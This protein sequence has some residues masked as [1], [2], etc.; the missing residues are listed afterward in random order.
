MKIDLTKNTIIC[1]DN[2]KWLENIPDRSF[3]LCY[4]DPPYFS[5]KNRDIVWKNG[6][7]RHSFGDKFQGDVRYY[8][9]WMRPRIELIHRK[10]K[11]TGSIFL[12]CDW[13]A[14]HRL[15][16]LLDDIFK[17][18]NFRNEIIWQRTPFSGSSKSR[19]QQFPVIHDTIFYYAKSKEHKTFICP[20]LPYSEEYLRRFKHKDAV[21]YYRKTLLKTYSEETLEKLK[22]ENKLILPQKEGAKYSYKQYLDTSRGTIPIGTIWTDINMLN[23]V[24]KERIGYPTQ[25]PEKLIE[26]IIRCASKEGDLILDCFVGGGTTAKVCADLNR[27]FIVGDVS[28]VAV[29]MTAT[30]LQK[31]GVVRIDIKNLAKTRE[32]FLNMNATDFEK[33]V[34]DVR[35]W[36]H[37]GKVNDHN[38]DG[39][40]PSQQ[41][42]QI[43]NHNKP[44]G[45]GEIEKF[46]G[47]LVANHKTKGIFVAWDYTT[48]ARAKAAF[49]KQEQG[50][51]IDLM[52]CKDALE[53]L[54]LDTEHDALY[55]KIFNKLAPEEWR[56]PNINVIRNLEEV[57]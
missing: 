50:I 32:Q 49:Y 13:H 16:G 23:P 11:E 21:G 1:G 37:T 2:V 54:I 35:G 22:Q 7:E 55:D 26:R 43:K 4:I 44:T 42:I 17:S 20:S 41:I 12:Q 52:T 57:S 24:A 27:R 31:V 36:E 34:C 10:L 19:S 25:K 53:S 5:G 29:R 33:F 38:I 40:T 51:E 28:P 3:D 30:R 9:E 48:Q 47:T 39:Y 45:P 6:T 18:Q 8:I 56:T 46:F 14:S 15:R